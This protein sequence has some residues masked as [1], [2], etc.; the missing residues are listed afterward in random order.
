LAKSELKYSYEKKKP[1]KTKAFFICLAI[2]AFLWIVH[3][4]NSVYNY[5]LKVPVVFR[6]IPRNKKPL[7][8]L[9]EALSV[10]VKASGLRLALILFN[11]PFTAL[12][13]DF[14]TLK[15]VNRNQN[16]VLSSS[17]LDFKKVLRFETQIKHIS[18]DTLYFSEKVG[19]QKNVPVK[20]PLYL[21]CEEGYGYKHPVITPA[22]VTIWGDTALTVKVD[23]IYTQPFT[24]TNMNKSVNTRLELLRPSTEI[25]S[26]VSE[27]NVS[28]EVD[29]L[30]EQSI[31]LSLSDVRHP[32]KGQIHIFPD[33]V[34]VRFTAIQNAF[35]S[36]DTA[37]FRAM[38]DSDKINAATKKCPVF[39][40][41]VPGNVT[42]MDIQPKEVEIIIFHKK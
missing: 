27:V 38:I 42:V 32:A 39:L 16:Y 30:V 29:K 41:T 15:S 6:N 31:F 4:L 24:L 34:Q 28:I 9:P 21:K 17:H 20:V 10:D 37:L 26:G 25:Y 7:I 23:T 33:R 1:G 12:E 11:R 8:H 19:F 36:E 13:V 18:P 5:N 3:S 40:S 22:F 35:N 2:A 14:N